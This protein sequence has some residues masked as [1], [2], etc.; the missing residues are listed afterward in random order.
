MKNKKGVGIISGPL[1]KIT[2]L[3]VLIIVVLI[4]LWKMGM[5]DFFL[6]LEDFNNTEYG[7]KIVAEQAAIPKDQKSKDYDGE[8]YPSVRLIYE[9]DPFGYDD[10]SDFFI[11]RWN[12]NVTSRGAVQVSI[13]MKKAR[14]WLLGEP[15]KVYVSNEWLVNPDLMEKFRR[16]EGI[17][18]YMKKD[19]INIARSES[20]EEMFEEIAEASKRREAAL[21]FNSVFFFW[22][23]YTGQGYEEEMTSEEI[24]LRLM[25]LHQNY[26]KEEIQE[27]IKQNA[28][29]KSMGFNLYFDN[30]LAIIRWNFK[31]QKTE[32]N[33]K[34]NG[35]MLEKEAIWS[36]SEEG[37]IQLLEKKGKLNKIDHNDLRLIGDLLNINVPSQLSERIVKTLRGDTNIYAK[38]K[39]GIGEDK[40]LAME[41]N[42]IEYIMYGCEDCNPDEFF[43]L[44]GPV[45][46]NV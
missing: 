11:F 9:E 32:L 14:W 24:K 36:I 46:E 6:N 23:Q 7:K 28:E 26:Y 34:P 43:K 3:A 35:K 19:I 39:S 45:I 18:A 38:H 16:Q 44:E 42:E 40:K 25:L 15:S 20:E 12:P 17:E 10:E 30:D 41:E 33:L 31:T 21:D 2:L 5:L 37:M 29:F 1:L 13:L 8:T 27:A 4:G 22:E